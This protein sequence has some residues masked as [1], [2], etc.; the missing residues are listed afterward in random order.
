MLVDKK[1]ESVIEKASEDHLYYV[2]KHKELFAVPMHLST[3]QY[4]NAK[5]MRNQLK[6]NELLYKRLLAFDRGG[7][8]LDIGVGP[9]FLEYANNELGKK[10]HLSTVEWEEQ[11]DHFKCVRDSWKVTVDYECNDIL[12]DDFKIHNCETYYDYVLLQRFFPVYKTTGTQ[13]IDDV[14]TKFV[15]YAKTAIIIESDTNWT[16]AQWKYLL[17]ISKERIKVYGDFNM[18]IIDLEQYK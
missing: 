18:F 9:A 4:M 11:V 10:L 13:R 2:M 14:L 16:K 6:F 7:I 8:Y 17:S 1:R 5:N 3:V 15:P 12:K